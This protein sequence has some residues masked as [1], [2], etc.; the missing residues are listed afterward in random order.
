MLLHIVSL[1]LYALSLIE[2]IENEK[3]L[4]RQEAIFYIEIQG[5][6]LMYD[7]VSYAIKYQHR[8]LQITQRKLYH[9][10]KIIK[11]H[12]NLLTPELIR[13]ILEQWT[14]SDLVRQIAL[15]Q[16]Q[17]SLLEQKN[18]TY[19]QYEIFLNLSLL[20]TAQED[21]K[22]FE[23]DID[24]ETWIKAF[25]GI[26]DQIKS[27]H[28]FWYFENLE[29]IK[30]QTLIDQIWQLVDALSVENLS[31]NPR[32]SYFIDERFTNQMAKNKVDLK[33]DRPAVLILDHVP[34]GE[35]QEQL[36]F[37][38]AQGPHHFKLCPKDQSECFDYDVHMIAKHQLKL[39]LTLK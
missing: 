13:S 37:E 32:Y 7:E 27:E 22:I 36:I 14:K 12:T 35:I 10:G 4:D 28:L 38:L 34:Y 30:S 25:A 2:S 1:F 19:T 31:E 23:K 11:E 6:D 17:I 5:K 9:Q 39:N 29:L 8:I 26:L 16:K 3:A 15:G 33:V 21:L 20:K 24:F 18:R